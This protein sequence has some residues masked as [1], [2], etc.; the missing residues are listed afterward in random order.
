[1]MIT[2]WTIIE[3]I[4]DETKRSVVEKIFRTYK[5][6]MV[7]LAMEILHNSY[8]A[9]D[10]VQD[11]V[12]KI[13]DHAESF[14]DI[15]RKEVWALV[16]TYTKNAALNLY[17]K[18]QRFSEYFESCENMDELCVA[19]NAEQDVLRCIMQCE[20]STML[21]RAVESLED[22]YRDVLMMKYYYRFDNEKIATLLKLEYTQVGGRLFRAKKQLKKVLEEMGYEHERIT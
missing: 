6:Q 11:A 7:K 13:M 22:K 17:R 8:D 15:P 4:P 10:A 2:I 9:E 14:R 18:N 19:Q 21:I 3:S 16:S 20:D 12:Y 5:K 1:M